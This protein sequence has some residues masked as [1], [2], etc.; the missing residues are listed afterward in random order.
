MKRAAGVAVAAILC[1]AT[2]AEGEPIRF[3]AP[4]QCTAGDKTVV[5]DPGV[6]LPEPDW[7]K[8]DLEVHRLQT[9]ETRLTAENRSLRASADSW[10]PGWKILASA[11]AIGLGGGYYLATR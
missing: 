9:A 1:V 6:Y 7:D 5:L 2:V 8:L 11:L 3:G 4:V 10:R